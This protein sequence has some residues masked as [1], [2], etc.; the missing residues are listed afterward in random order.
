MHS[1]KSRH[2]LKTLC[3]V[4]LCFLGSTTGFIQLEPVQEPIQIAPV[5]LIHIAPI[6]PVCTCP[7]PTPFQLTEEQVA[8]INFDRVHE[9]QS[10]PDLLQAAITKHETIVQLT[11]QQEQDAKSMYP[12]LFQSQSAAVPDYQT[13]P[14]LVEIGFQPANDYGYRYKRDFRSFSPWIRKCPA[15]DKIENITLAINKDG[16]LVQVI[17]PNSASG[18]SQWILNEKCLRNYDYCGSNCYSFLS[19]RNAVRYVDVLAIGFDDNTVVTV[20]IHQIRVYCC[21]A[22]VHRFW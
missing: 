16:V 14:S 17:Q 8:S 9:L 15:V 2:I 12:T 18:I 19:C 4:A 7:Q 5:D 13:D 6:C 10:N 11:P 22:Q 20:S 3:V 21:T 1:L